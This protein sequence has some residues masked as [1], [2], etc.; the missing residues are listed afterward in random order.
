MLFQQ[1][2]RDSFIL[3]FLSIL[4]TLSVTAE[5]PQTQFNDKTFKLT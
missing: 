4:V 5:N 3:E 1:N 2:R